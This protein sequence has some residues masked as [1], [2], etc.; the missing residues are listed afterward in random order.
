LKESLRLRPAMA[1]GRSVKEFYDLST[2]EQES[3][4]DRLTDHALC[5][6]RKLSWRGAR[7]ARGGTVPGGYEPYDLALDALADALDG[8]SRN[9][10]REKYPSMEGFLKSVINSKISNLVNLVENQSE[11][12]MLPA[13]GKDGSL[14]QFDVAGKGPNPLVMLIDREALPKFH[15]AAIRE[16]EGEPVLASILECM[17]AEIIK[18]SEIAEAVSTAEKTITVNDVNNALKRLERKLKKL[19]TRTPPSKKGKP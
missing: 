3:L 9:W 8:E 10:N 13:T 15:A 17:E 5:K 18:P 19:D 14:V 12:R 4:L 7:I 11:R 2:T 6:M 16:L 1:Q